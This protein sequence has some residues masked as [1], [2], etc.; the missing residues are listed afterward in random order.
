MEDET[1]KVLWIATLL[2]LLETFAIYM[3]LN[4][5]ALSLTIGA[6]AGLGGYALNTLIRALRGEK[7]ERPAKS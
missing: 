3:G 1:I 6:L 2:V 4:G 7:I 5:W